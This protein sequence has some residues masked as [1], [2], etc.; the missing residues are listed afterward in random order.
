[1][2]ETAAKSHKLASAVYLITGFFGDHEPMKWKLRDLS[3]NLMAEN[4]KDKS[5]IAR[6]ILS[7]FGIAKNA[8]LVSD[9]NYEILSQELTKFMKWLENPLKSIFIEEAAPL[10]EALPRPAERESIKD[11]YIEKRPIDRPALKEF[12]VVSVKKNSRQSIIIALLKRKKEIMI[13]DVSPLI[14]GCSEK[15]IQRELLS[16]VAQG[17]LKKTGEKRWSRY[18]LA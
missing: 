16:M 10:R 12:G 13:K 9:Q 14:E 15:T 4:G 17:I 1:M 5:S 11:N 2:S 6:E 3:L 8:G 18:S 7:L